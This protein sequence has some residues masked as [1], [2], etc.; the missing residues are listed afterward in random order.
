MCNPALRSVKRPVRLA[1]VRLGAWPAHDRLRINLFTVRDFDRLLV[2]A[3][4]EKVASTL[5]G[6]GPATLLQ[7]KMLSDG[8]GLRLNRQLQTLADRKLPGLRS[9]A[10]EYLVL[11]RKSAA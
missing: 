5:Y 11:A 4:F 2:L 9:T 7:R 8:A 1:L 6:Y 10:A 3:G